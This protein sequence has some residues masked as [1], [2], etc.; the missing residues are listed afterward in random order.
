MTIVSVELISSHKPLQYNVSETH[1]VTIML[2]YTS[3][4]KDTT[5]DQYHNLTDESSC[6]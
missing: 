3:T 4:G 6:F 2:M 1:H 5:S